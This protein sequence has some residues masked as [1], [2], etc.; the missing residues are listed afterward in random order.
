MPDDAKVKESEFA[1]F[2]CEHV[3]RVEVCVECSCGE[4]LVKE[5]VDDCFCVFCGGV[6][7]FA[8]FGSFKEVQGEDVFC[9]LFP[10]DLGD[11]D[12]SVLGCF[13]DRF[14]GVSFRNE[15]E[16]L[17]CVPFEFACDAGWV[18][19]GCVFFE[20]VCKE[21]K[22][23]EVCFDL[24]FDVWP[25]D[26]DGNSGSVFEACFVNLGDAGRAERCVVDVGEYCAC[27][28]FEASLDFGDNGFD[29]F[30]RDFVKEFAEFVAVFLGDEVGA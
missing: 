1:V 3:S 26:F 11:D 5:C 29:G 20:P 14:K 12:V 4:Y 28:F 19:F 22:D 8:E 2:E 9:G 7:G 27:R 10:V 24:F 18:E 15:V 6:F 21:A 23:G 17:F 25:A 30:R 13:S 16:L